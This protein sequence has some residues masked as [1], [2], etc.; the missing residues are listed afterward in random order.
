[1]TGTRLL[2][3]V[4]LL[5]RV[6]VETVAL[7]S[8]GVLYLR[9]HHWLIPHEGHNI[10]GIHRV[11][12]TLGR[13]IPCRSC[14]ERHSSLS[15]VLIVKALPQNGIPVA[16]LDPC[17]EFQGPGIC[18]PNTGIVPCAGLDCPKIGVPPDGKALSVRV[19]L[20][21]APF[22]ENDDEPTDKVYAGC[23]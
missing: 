9:R 20:P 17:P 14:G 11:L 1:L 10:L 15:G 21:T 18:A 4:W 16:R 8:V 22:Q 12:R 5:A 19:L 2:G 6:L 23:P 3:K 7:A 13:I